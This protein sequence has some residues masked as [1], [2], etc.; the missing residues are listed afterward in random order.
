M[1]STYKKRFSHKL[2]QLSLESLNVRNEIND[3]QINTKT[4]NLVNFFYVQLLVPWLVKESYVLIPFGKNEK[5][6]KARRCMYEDLWAI[7]ID[8]LQAKN[9][10]LCPITEIKNLFTG[11]QLN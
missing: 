1:I 7:Q 8:L 4:G 10:S 5:F 2:H 9:N 3:G 11:F 6:S